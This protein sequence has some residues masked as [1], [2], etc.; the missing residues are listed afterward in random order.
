MTTKSIMSK[1]EINRLN[2]RN[3]HYCKSQDFI[4]INYSDFTFIY[5]GNT[6]K[7]LSHKSHYPSC[8]CKIA[9]KVFF[10]NPDT[11]LKY[12][13]WIKLTGSFSIPSGYSIA[14]RKSEYIP[15][16]LKTIYPFIPNEILNSPED[17]KYLPIS[18]IDFKG[19][20]VNSPEKDLIP[21][22]SCNEPN[23]NK[24]KY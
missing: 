6:Y 14:S 8:V 19:K 21:E 15:V 12:Y 7:I 16:Y 13:R 5:K 11:G 17:K 2:V 10:I 3:K 24:E 9:K 20:K 4:N 23:I 18:Q 1:G 22:K